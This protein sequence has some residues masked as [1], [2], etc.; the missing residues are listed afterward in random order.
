M[1]DHRVMRIDYGPPG[2][3]GVKQLAYV[4]DLG[5]DADYKATGLHALAK[6]VAMAALGTVAFA[7]VTGKPTLRKSALGVW[8][9]ATLVRWLTKP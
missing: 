7:W 3:L 5:D 6:P 4:G 9:G 8:L 1:D 2:A